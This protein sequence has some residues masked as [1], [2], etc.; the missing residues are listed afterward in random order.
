MRTSRG[1]TLIELCFGMA[2]VAVLAGMAAP[3]FRMSLH[4]GAVRSATFE[5]VAGLQQARGTS[6]VESRPGL[7]CPSDPAGTCLPAGTPSSYWRWSVEADDGPPAHAETLPTG[8]ALRA[9]RSPIRFWP[10]SLGATTGTLTICD[11][12]GI[13]PPRAI[14]VSVTGRP[15][16]TLAPESAC[17]S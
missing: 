13:A 9:S 2:I 8:V 14:V 17:R 5:V 3:G 11:V 10:D 1:I 15:R 12:H 7:L 4:A 16:T 6:I